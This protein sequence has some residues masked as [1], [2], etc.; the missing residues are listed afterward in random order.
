MKWRGRRSSDNVIKGRRSSKGRIPLSGGGLIL[1]LI[2]SLITGNNPLDIIS[3]QVNEKQN[4]SQIEERIDPNS[5]RAQYQEFL[6]VVLAD[7]EDVWHNIFESYGSNY[8][9]AKLNLYNDNTRSGCGIA[10][11]Q[12]GPFYCPKDETVYIDVAF[13]DDLQKKFDAPG[14]FAF[15]YVL[16]HEIGHHVQNQFGITD[17]VFAFKGKVSE[18]EFNN[19]MVRLELQADYYAGVFANH[20]KN[21]GYLDPGDIEEAMNAASGVGDDRIQEMTSGQVQPDK[22]THGTSEQRMRWFNRGYEYGDLDHGDT[23]N[24]KEL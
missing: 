4:Q 2:I 13:A 9:E 10:S 1:I 16:A 7:T 12:M 23:F 8:R 6:G 3:G 22:F 5:P 19:Y 14:D 15:A 11:S 18:K 20:I 21:K 17:Q 24:A